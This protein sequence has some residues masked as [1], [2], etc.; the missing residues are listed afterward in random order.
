V[1]A[2]F[3]LWALILAHRLIDTLSLLA[4]DAGARPA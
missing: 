3:N 4:R 2:C 1:G